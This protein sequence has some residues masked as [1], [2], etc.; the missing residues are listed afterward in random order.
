MTALGAVPVEVGNLRLIL[1]G[2]QS[3]IDA[4]ELAL[5]NA[6]RGSIV[7]ANVTFFGKTLTLFAGRH[8]FER[9]T[10]QQQ[11]VLQTAAERTVRHV[12]ARPLS[13]AF[14]FRRFCNGRRVVVA[15]PADLRQLEHA[16]Q[17]VYAQLERDPLTRSLI[18]RIRHLKATTARDP[19]PAASRRCSAPQVARTPAGR[20]LAAS[21]LNGTYRWVITEAAARASGTYGPGDVYPS[22]FTAILRDGRWLFDGQ[23]PDTGTYTIVGRQIRFVWPRV[24]AT[25]VFTFMRERDGTLHLKPVL[26]MDRG[27]QFVWSGAPWRRAGPPVKQIP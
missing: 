15:S 11:E 25:L 26:P 20:T 10:R 22:V 27:D 13:E 7:T 24:G 2:P 19:S 16:A 5:A 4:E 6:P 8:A 23:P 12:V 9:L 14:I 3:Q 1:T 18:A 17:P 21:V